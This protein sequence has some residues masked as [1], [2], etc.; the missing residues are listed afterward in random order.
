MHFKFS[1]AFNESMKWERRNVRRLL[2]LSL[3]LLLP[4]HQRL[5]LKPPQTLRCGLQ[6]PQEGIL[7]A[8]SGVEV[9]RV[10]V[11]EER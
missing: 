4:W 7:C 9:V 8:P 10:C 11:H 1:L 5:H 2:T 3:L 6:T